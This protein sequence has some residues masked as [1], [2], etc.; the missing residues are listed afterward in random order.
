MGQSVAA[1]L[2][3]SSVTK[4]QLAS[5]PPLSCQLLQLSGYVDSNP[6][7]LYPR[8]VEPAGGGKQRA[9]LS[10]NTGIWTDPYIGLAYHWIVIVRCMI[11][12]GYNA[13]NANHH[14]LLNTHRTYQRRKTFILKAGGQL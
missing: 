1:R 10:R 12:S 6:D 5:C 3:R 4:P 11:Y 8:P 9:Q 14:N 13:T 7:M 2:T